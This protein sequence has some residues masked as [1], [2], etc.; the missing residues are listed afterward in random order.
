MVPVMEPV[1][2]ISKDVELKVKEKAA[3][4]GIDPAL[5]CAIVE[6]ESGGNP[7]AI[8][9][10][11]DFYR[12]YVASQSLSPTEKTARS[13]SW[14]L[15][16]TMGQSVRDAGYKGDLAALCDPDTGLTWGLAVLQK[17]LALAHGDVRRGLLFWNG[18]S[19]KS[20][21]DEVLAKV[22]KYIDQ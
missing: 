3:S 13:I 4:L 16:Q 5:A 8:R 7:W 9:Y 15:F 21:P 22:P 6:Q 17:K 2:Q 1:A 19:N 18:G 14:G 10:E 12:H 20:Y 11:P